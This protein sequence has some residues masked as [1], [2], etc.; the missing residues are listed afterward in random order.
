MSLAIL[1][2]VH[3]LVQDRMFHGPITLYDRIFPWSE[4]CILISVDEDSST[5]SE[6]RL[7]QSVMKWS[8]GF[9]SKIVVF[10]MLDQSAFFNQKC[11]Q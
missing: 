3:Y 5:F 10:S 9:V 8:P 6:I 2:S 4:V 1:T 7:V 11:R